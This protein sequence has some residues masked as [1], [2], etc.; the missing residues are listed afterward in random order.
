[1]Y[2]ALHAALSRGD[3]DQLR[4]CLLDRNIEARTAVG[5]GP[6]STLSA[7]QLAA[8]YDEDL[9][10]TLLRRG[11]PL[12]LHS[13]CALGQVAAFDSAPG[14][15]G[16]TAEHLTPMGFALLKG[17]RDAVGELLRRGDD[18]TRP[19]ARIGFFVWEIEALGCGC[20]T[21]LHMACAHG[22][23]AAAPAMVASLLDAGAD[24]GARCPLGETPLHL[25]AT[26]SWL[27]VIEALLAGGADVD[28]VTVPA[29]ANVHQ[30]ASPPHAV[31]VH[32]Q[33]PLM[34]AARE[35][36]EAGVRL[37]L[38][39]G[40]DVHARDSAGGTALHVAARPWWG[41]NAAIVAMLLAAGADARARNAAGS[42]PGELAL[43]AGYQATA[44]LLGDRA[45][46]K[47]RSGSAA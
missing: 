38:A 9:A 20:W 18:A 4:R 34:I 16:D 22:Y 17:Q 10:A 2:D 8:L 31:P 14:N 43:A 33:T 6:E 46:P 24:I 5:L 1:M 35:G 41:E 36:G 23:A 15:F 3:W 26:Y 21:P 11:V 45:A 47:S 27:P 29:P 37:L 12:D 13:A 32:G 42:T 44:E 19:L 39:R 25:A 40:A 28:E 7:L 30:L